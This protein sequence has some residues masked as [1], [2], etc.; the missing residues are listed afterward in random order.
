MD[1][2]RF[3]L[4]VTFAMLVFML[5]QAWEQDYGP[6]PEIAAIVSPEGIKAKEDLP[7]TAEA[8]MQAESTLQNPV[9]SPV[10]VTST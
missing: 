2:L 6:K 9:A 8:S 7:T 10:A 1:N 3:V 5:W 4:V